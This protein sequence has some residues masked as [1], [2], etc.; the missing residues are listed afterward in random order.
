ITIT[1]TLI[2]WS[3][4]DTGDD[5]KILEIMQW[6]DVRLGN[7]GYYFA[8]AEN[9]RITANDTLDLS[10]TTN[11][12]F[13]FSSCKEIGDVGTMN[14]WDVSSITNMRGMFYKAYSFNQPI[15]DWDVS[16]VSDMSYM[17]YHATHFNQ[18]IGNW[19]VS[20]VT[21]MRG[22]FYGYHDWVDCI[23]S[24]FNQPLGNWDVSSVTDMS[25]MFHATFFNHS[26]GNWDVSSVEDMSGM[27]SLAIFFNQPIKDWD[28]SSVEDM[29]Y[30]F[31]RAVFFNMPIGNWDVS[32]VR[33][34]RGMFAFTY[35]HSEVI[36]HSSF[37]QPIG[38]WDVSSVTDMRWMFYRAYS[39]N[40]PI[41]NW[42]VSRVTDMSFMFYSAYSFNQPIGDWGV[43]SVTNMSAMFYGAYSFDQPI[44]DWNV[45]SVTNMRGMFSSAIDFNQLISKWDVS[46]VTD[47]SNM[48]FNVTLSISNYNELLIGWSELSLHNDITFV[49]G[50]SLNSNE[51]ADA[52]QIIITNF[53]WTIY[54]GF[55]PGPYLNMYVE[56]RLEAGIEIS[57]RLIDDTQIEQ[58]E[59]EEISDRLINDKNIG[60]TEA[61][62]IRET[63][64][65]ILLSEIFVGFLV[66]GLG[67]Y[68]IRTMRLSQ[69]TISITKSTKNTLQHIFNGNTSKYLYLIGAFTGKDGIK[70]E[71]N[72]PKE[73]LEHKFLMQ[74]VRLAMM[75]ILTENP[76]VTNI[77]MKNTLGISWGEFSNNLIAL[78]KNNLVVTEERFVDGVAR[79]SISIT[80]E[81]LSQYNSLVEVLQEFLS[82]PDYESYVEGYSK[83]LLEKSKNN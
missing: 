4:N 15:G 61:E 3:F 82:S 44:G 24:V 52:K 66:F 31:E 42:D 8:G 60:E 63:L 80:P 1:G 16:S 72:I 73:M 9:L 68:M 27:F 22:M 69:R 57:H 30:M 2:G 70:T 43:S 13:A 26:I 76:Y 6:G 83:D 74:P 32:S 79:Q 67:G 17:F 51:S 75:K 62:E 12:D 23:H 46:S 19:D 65:R 77:E 25:Y 10:G 18:P 53:N 47:M 35:I 50:N 56:F 64:E 41:G 28:V 59:T 49:A 45:S 7:S 20:S 78:R 48:F 58:I 71:T 38:N 40:Q 54:D 21:D 34:M 5:L 55:D 39:F 14:N 29:S 37:N 36:D 33:N 11:L 81:G